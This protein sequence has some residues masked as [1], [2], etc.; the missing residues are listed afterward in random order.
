MNITHA[1]TLSDRALVAELGR[2][3]GQERAA[4]VALI[5]HLGRRPLGAWGASRRSIAWG[6]S[7]VRTTPTRQTCSTVRAA[8]VVASIYPSRDV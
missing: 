7:A 4:T 2:L 1:S 3:A 5:V 8:A 6:Y